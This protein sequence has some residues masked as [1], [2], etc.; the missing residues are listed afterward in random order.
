[1]TVTGTSRCVHAAHV[2]STLDGELV[3]LGLQRYGS[4]LVVPAKNPYPSEWVWVFAGYGCRVQR[5]KFGVVGGWHRHFGDSYTG[6]WG[7]LG[8]VIAWEFWV[9]LELLGW[10]PLENSHTL[11]EF[12]WCASLHEYC[13]DNDDPESDTGPND[14]L[15]SIMISTAVMPLICK[16]IEVGALNSYSALDTHNTINLAEQVEA[17]IGHNNPKFQ[18]TRYLL[19]TTNKLLF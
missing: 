18:V 6:A 7:G 10:N 2:E 8:L 9:W 3:V 11:D 17:S 16:V 12:S 4:A 15:V 14:D 1:M 5:S 13:G 19:V